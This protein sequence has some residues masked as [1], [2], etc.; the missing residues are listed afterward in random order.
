MSGKD[1]ILA[2]IKKCLALSKSPEPHEAAAALRQA[3]KLMQQHNLSQQDV[4]LSAVKESRVKGSNSMYRPPSYIA[5]L[6]SIVADNFGCEMHL[7]TT[8][9]GKD[10]VFI[11]LEAN[12]QLSQYCFRVLLRQLQAARLGYYRQLRGKRS[13]K[14]ARADT[15]A[16]AWVYAVAELIK[17]FAQPVDT[18]TQQYMQAK[19]SQLSPAKQSNRSNA[20]TNYTDGNAGYRDGKQAQLHH[21][22]NGQQKHRLTAQ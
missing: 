13:N 3:Q 18:A 9:R 19:S 4:E 12:T 6:A 10:Y 15:Y 20:R 8:I 16:R 14:I 21:G 2:R 7:S 17:D 22:I 5:H 11:G 1:K